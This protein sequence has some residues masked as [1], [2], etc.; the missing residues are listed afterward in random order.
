M[1]TDLLRP[2]RDGDQ[3]HY[4]WAARQALRL[5]EPGTRLDSI[6][7]EGV[8]SGDGA[9]GKALE[10]VDLAEY[11]GSSDLATADRVVYRQL[12]HSTTQIGDE[13]TA[14]FLKGTL[15]GFA[16]RFADILRK[17]PDFADRVF[18]EVVSNRPASP[19]VHAAISEL[20]TER[21]PSSVS[22]NAIRYIR[23]QI[24]GVL[25]AP[26]IA[27]LCR[28]LRIDDTAPSLLR[29]RPLFEQDVSA[30]LPGAPADSALRLKEMIGSRATSQYAD[31]PRVDK[32]VVLAAIGTSEEALLPAPN[33]VQA[34]ETV[35]PTAHLATVTEQ[36]KLPE[37]SPILVHAPGGVGKSVLANNIGASMPAGSVT[38]V[39]DCFGNGTYRSP[40]SLRH[41]PKRAL[42]QIV[43]ELAAQGLCDPLI[44]SDTAEP[45]DYFRVF[46]K[47]LNNAAQ[48]VATRSPDALLVLVIDAADNAVLVA[49]E[50]GT[51]AFAPGLLRESMPANA[52]LLMLC[53]TERRQLLNPPPGHRDV[54]L[55]GFTQAES[56]VLLR[57]SFPR[58]DDRDTAEFHAR[59]GGNPRVQVTAL[60]SAASLPEVLNHLGPAGGADRDRFGELMD[61]LMDQVKD[62][63]HQSTEIGQICI[64]LAALRP[65]VPI[66]VLAQLAQVDVA[67]VESFVAD[68]GHP[69]LID[70]GAVQFRD[71]PTESWF[72][73]RFRPVG[74]G[75]DALL[76]KL[77]PIAAA[78]PYAAASIPALLWEA[79]RVDD[80]IKLALSN[81]DLPFSD[82]NDEPHNLQRTEIDQERAQFALKAALRESRE[83]EAARLAIKVGALAAGR[84]RR[85]EIFREHTDLA[86]AFLDPHIVEQLVADRSMTG[87]WPNS[88]LP[89]EGALL[90]G[91][92]GRLH[93]ARSRLRSAQT[94]MRAWTRDAQQRGEN[95]GVSHTDIAQ[96]A[97]GLL[98][99]DGTKACAEF[100]NRWNPKTVA[101]DAGIIVVRR[102]IDADRISDLN[103][104]ASADGQPFLAFAV[105]QGCAEA[106]QQIDA[107]A[108]GEVIDA[109]TAATGRLE[110]SDRTTH[111][112]TG[113]GIS[114]N[115]VAAVTWAV[116]SGLRHGLL[117]GAAA[118]ELIGRYLPEDLGHRDGGQHFEQGTLGLLAGFALQSRAR[119]QAFD[120]DA[121]A[122]PRVREAKDKP[123]Y[124][125]TREAHDYNANVTPLTGWLELWIDVLTGSRNHAVERYGQLE[126]V[127]T[128]SFSYE[129]PRFFLNSVCRIAAHALTAITDEGAHHRYLAFCTSNAS[130]LTD[131]TLTR[132]V[133]ICA[134]HP[135]LHELANEL[136]MAVRNS[137]DDMR[138]DAGTM[139]N[140]LI[141]LSRATYR[142]ADFEARAHFEQAVAVA[143]RLGDDAHQRWTMVVQLTDAASATNYGQPERAY[144]LA[145]VAENLEPYLGD[146]IYLADALQSVGKLCTPAAIA[147]GSRWR[148]RRVITVNDLGRALASG[149]NP[150]LQTAPIAATALLP[151]SDHR[152]SLDVITNAMRHH[153]ERASLFIKVLGE[154]ERA[155]RHWP[156]SLR[157]LDEVAAETHTSLA[158]TSFAPDTRTALK[159]TTSVHSRRWYGDDAVDRHENNAI[160][161]YDLMSPAGWSEALEQQ[162]RYTRIGGVYAQ[163]ANVPATRKIGMVNA[164]S[165]CPHISAWDVDRLIATI[166]PFDHLSA[167][168][169]AE[170]RKLAKTAISRFCRDLV[171]RT[172]D[173]INFD[174]LA[175]ATREQSPDYIG[176]ALR[177]VGATAPR[178]TADEAFALASR[179]STRITPQQASRLLDEGL[180]LF[181]EVADADAG[182]GRFEG[183]PP[184]PESVPH[185]VA[186]MLWATLAD[187]DDA[188]RWRAAHSVRLLLAL[189]CRDITGLLLDFSL[190]RRSTEPFIDARL[191]FYGR[192]ARQWLLLALARAAQDTEAQ[193]AAAS[194]EP[195]LRHVL[196]DADP[197]I[198]MQH[199]ARVATLAL[200]QRSLIS[201]N[202]IES[203]AVLAIGTPTAVTLVAG[204]ATNRR[205]VHRLRDIATLSTNDLSADDPTLDTDAEETS[206]APTE[207]GRPSK[208]FD[209]F[210]DF[211]DYWCSNLGDAFGI[212]TDSIQQLV[213][214][215]MIDRWRIT[216]TGK[217]T[218]DPRHHLKLYRSDKYTSKSEYPYSDDF[219]FYLSSHALFELAGRLI[220]TLPVITRPD[221]PITEWANFLHQHLPTR[222]DGRWLADRRDAAPAIQLQ[223]PD[224]GTTRDESND[225]WRRGL[226]SADSAERL[227]PEPEWVVVWEETWSANYSRTELVSISSALVSA[228][229][230]PALLRALQT[231]PAA[232]TFRL[233]AADDTEF[234]SDA[235]DFTMTG[236]IRD[237]GHRS[238]I[239]ARDPNSGISTFPPARPTTEI[240]ATLGA[241]RD[242]D[243]RTWSIEDTAVIQSLV[244][245][246][247]SG[248]GS[249][250]RG[251]S[252]ERLAIR[253]STLTELLRRTERSLIVRVKTTRRIKD[254][255]TGS[256]SERKP[257]DD[258]TTGIYTG[259]FLFDE[260]G[261]R[262]QL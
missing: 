20:A 212:G 9:T 221:E 8:S 197:H 127:F 108:V 176:Q 105:A 77:K 19:G 130:S 151:L 85:L 201:L 192:H 225:H 199:S 188:N 159:D 170:I 99:T 126:T 248:D 104:L 46:K 224:N 89:I 58:A 111:D 38:V 135:H 137:I 231:A 178:F 241:T 54:A 34:P 57:A 138:T 240:A 110:L 47:R 238:G 60:A 177:A 145:Q 32:V 222:D 208:R 146:G 125:S 128:K 214:E 31:N 109:L 44:P 59:T 37:A 106:G 140:S 28:Q 64:G 88:N 166:S 262:H 70:G 45:D 232:T 90:S 253:I 1:T 191:P 30:L 52:R 243:F 101:F 122:G 154:R 133:R 100:L 87:T 187:T 74:E 67:L 245:G 48:I 249:Q 119:G 27:Q 33:L 207:P 42:V 11:W 162:A 95:S 118:A 141:M 202:E 210:M 169:R 113:G 112:Y 226:N 26:Q 168:L 211:A 15:A 22:R 53:R 156:E 114:D 69:L 10:V 236:W 179:L 116:A 213:E 75:L 157:K 21:A 218:E 147:M 50:N 184:V 123:S 190:G 220:A 56:A 182:D 3:F 252:G 235:D 51:R 175:A 107:S 76:A 181:D 6:Y 254:S 167:G 23:Q 94:W 43:N 96:V 150:L 102:L 36:L 117:G 61:N 215:I 261:T 174:D 16:K 7:V 204:W 93:Q 165:Q 237:P 200:K 205:T 35:V 160:P 260:H 66:R 242:L 164:F 247:S 12:K 183:L 78:D 234:T 142:L 158:E 239:D 39:Y 172:W 132:A 120:S 97:W 79:R 217:Y 62:R 24:G 80:L 121:V 153:P 258:N 155:V 72:R 149:D 256:T 29:L 257:D 13:W 129:P 131:A 161:S 68:L 152:D 41:E 233:P 124:L 163:A 139:I 2:S 206:E 40:S 180:H 136:A 209:F 228:K 194:F 55:S 143:D 84:T 98:K 103:G 193:A 251:S 4:V 86:A 71:E 83:F 195:L 81:D 255:H 186:G 189:D 5:L 115:G 250:E 244:W 230:G 17:Q 185:A 198:V 18:F 14:S 173:R 144:R 63:H 216:F 171:L 92:D 134:A 148:D 229:T 223:E 203:K 73:E 65:M 91:A 25:T 82:E 219:D 259:Y 246:D 196:L 227:S 49:A